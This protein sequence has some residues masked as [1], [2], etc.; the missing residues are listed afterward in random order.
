[1]KFNIPAAFFT[2][3]SV[4]ALAFAEGLH[5]NQ[6]IALPGRPFG[7]VLSSDQLHLF[8]SLTGDGH[9]RNFGVAVLDRSAGKVTLNRVV[10]LEA[11]PAGLVLT[12]DGKLLIMACGDTVLVLDAQELV[13]TGRAVE[14]CRFSDGHDAGS[15]YV[16]VTADDSTL[17][18]SDESAAAITVVD[19]AR[20]LREGPKTAII[21]KIS[22][23]RAPIA[24]TFSPDQ[25]WL[26]TTCEIAADRWGW[27][28]TIPRE[29]SSDSRGHPRVPEGAMVV[30]DVAKAKTDPARAVVSRLPAGG[31][32]VRLVISPSG[33]R[34]YVTARNSN[35]VVVFDAAKVVADPMRARIA[36]VPVGRSPVPIALADHGT[37]ILVGNSNR[38]ATDRMAS[39]TLT[40]IDAT[41]VSAGDKSVLGTV[42]VGAFPRDLLV[43]PDGRTVILANFLSGTLQIMDAHALP[44]A[45][46]PN[47]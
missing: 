23:G 35:A 42:K 19:L 41:Q 13:K 15:V 14:R 7:V 30:V 2:L 37:Q 5:P 12:H 36:V 45:P 26:Y 18:V 33:D 4:A 24:L 9:G 10:S 47:G 27:P 21:G 8:V 1:M 16:N 34:I 3:L 44:R 17:F 6:E 39:S 32:P 25:R 46:R 11:R 43:T 28:A 22:T 38:F 40:V 20:L 31:S 29:G